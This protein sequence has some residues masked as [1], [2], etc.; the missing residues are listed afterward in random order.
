MTITLNGFA[1]RLSL[2]AWRDAAWVSLPMAQTDRGMVADHKGLRADLALQPKG[3]RIDYQLR[4]AAPWRTRIRLMLAL[5]ESAD[6]FHLIPGNIH[7]DNNAA[8]VRP[9]EFPCL[10]KSRPHERN[11][12]ALWEFRADRASHP[13]SILCGTAGAVGISIDPYSECDEADEGFIRN[14]VLA[15]L[16][17]SFGVS[18]GYGN[19]PLTFSEK[20]VFLPATADL[21][22]GASAGGT[23][24]AAA[25]NGRLEAHRIIRALHETLRDVPKHTRSHRD[26]LRALADAFAKVNFSPEVGQYTNRRCDVPLD[27]TLRPWRAIVEI[28]WTGGSMLAYPFALAERIFDDLKLPKTSSQLFDEICSGF[29]EAS[30]FISDTCVNRFTKDRPAEWNQ[31]HINGWWSGFLPQTRD[32]HCAY[33]NAH[34]AYYILRLG[35]AKWQA[36]AFRVLNTAISLQR[37]DGAFGYIFS[38]K[39]KKVIDFDGFAGCW[40][41]AAAALAWKITREKKYLESGSRAMDFYWPFVKALNCWGSPMDTFKSVDSEGNLAFIRAA[42]H[43]HEFTGDDKYLQMLTDGANYEYLWRYGF[44]ARPQCPPLKGSNW[45]SCGGTITSVSNPH[46]HP[47]GVVATSDLR[48][49]A[50]QSKDN[51][52]DHRAED[53]LAWL[54]NTMELY[55][56][57]MGYGCYG[58]LSE[59]TCPSDGLLAERFADDGSPA[60]TWW[61]YNAWAAGSAMEALA[62]HIL[63]T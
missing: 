34:A 26:A 30:G 7:G 56:D 61:S 38:G 32:N 51:Y 15:A 8:Y 9:G 14:G 44:R 23:V 22:H 28:G 40:F 63:S 3:D 45:N 58:V 35:V 36:T 42:R 16:P 25:G 33:T 43:L 57:V 29:D 59:R 12:A 5:L 46:I 31:S 53:G 27:T 47:M 2:L 41:A 17:N 49:L 55:P 62:E 48:Y 39:E 37:E 54:M 18:I 24:F 13:V 21:S 4:F 1:L 19:D 52:H 60:S 6:L 20:T 50:K 11:C 10:T